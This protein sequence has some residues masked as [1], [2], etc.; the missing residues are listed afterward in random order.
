MTAREG[1]DLFGLSPAPA[2]AADPAAL[3]AEW[4]QGLACLAPTRDP[5]P[6]FRAGQWLSVHAAALDFLAN[7]AEA[8]AALG[9]STVALFGVH[10]AVGVRR[11]D[12]CGALMVSSGSPITEVT[13][14]RIRYRNGLVYRRVPPGG[15]SVP[16]W[17]VAAEQQ[18]TPAKL[19]P[20]TSGKALS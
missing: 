10:P 14:E 9:W 8:A 2:P 3:M 19:P 18:A 4:K 17:Q 1:L 7:T 5:C 12:C 11:V 6:G 20:A 13:P 16:V 15:P